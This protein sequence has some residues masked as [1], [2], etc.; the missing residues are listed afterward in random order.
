M[1]YNKFEDKAIE[2]LH[3]RI[4]DEND[5]PKWSKIV[6]CMNSNR[7]ALNGPNHEYTVAML[8]NRYQRMTKERMKKCRHKQGDVCTR[9]SYNEAEH[10]V[11]NIFGFDESI[12]DQLEYFEDLSTILHKQSTIDNS[13]TGIGN[14]ELPLLFDL[15]RSYEHTSTSINEYQILWD[16]V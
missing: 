3:Y 4:C 10:A 7:E 12:A 6:E 5:R 9:H 13:I 8:R 14:A 15:M 16:L 1:K 2:I 11:Y